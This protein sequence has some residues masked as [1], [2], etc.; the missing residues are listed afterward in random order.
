[1][2][3]F[4]TAGIRGSAERRVTPELAL[5]VARAVGTA[6]REAGDREFVVARDG[7]VTGP[8]LA[9][10][11]EAGL[12][13]A[14]A[15]VTRLGQ[16]PT[17]GLA[18]ASRG[19][20]GVMLTASHNPPADNGIKVFRDGVEYAQTAETDVEERVAAGAAPARWD[21]WGEAAEADVLASYREAVATYAAR[22]G[23]DPAGVRVAVDCGNG[24]AAL[25][26]PHVLRELGADVVTLNAN[27]DGHF[28]GRESKPT[29]ESLADLRAFVRDDGADFGIGHD[30][31][32][33]RIVVV[34][35]DGEV[36]HED[37]VLAVLAER[38]VRES[39]AADPVVVTTPNASGRIDERVRAAGGRVERVALGYLHDGIAA[40]REAG[41]D[42]VFAA[43]PWKH[44]HTGFGGWIDGVASAAV[45]TRLVAAEGLAGL[46]DP[47]TERPYRKVSV[48]C[49]D[50]AKVAVMERLAVTLPEAFPEASVSTEYGV[51]LA[52][53]DDAWALV[54]PSGT[55]PYVRVYAESDD[56]DELVAS[57]TD[58]VEDAVAD[59]G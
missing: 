33:D 42:V 16:L 55:E 28:P 45:L 32:A 9:A 11:V 29:P 7:R 14:G 51:R 1:M 46:R 41:S 3:L 27:V 8:S 30:G 6:A 52:F 40:A 37:T 21:E 57:V 13:S 35:A 43:E 34:D 22:F 20:H 4:G 38:Y 5:D 12:T 48:D 53:P 54:R 25:V 15:D 49:G 10:A 56:V 31:D 36:V 23:A 19:R 44:V 24:M 39:D 26:T 18:F 59:I 50:D 58:V 47:V 17:P 2:N